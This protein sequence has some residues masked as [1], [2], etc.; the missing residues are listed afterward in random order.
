MSVGE[1]SQD[2]VNMRS[3]QS[4]PKDSETKSL[5]QQ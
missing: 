5:P 4:I 1:N 3:A 2:S